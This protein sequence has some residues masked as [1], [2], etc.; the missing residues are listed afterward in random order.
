VIT[1]PESAQILVAGAGMSHYHWPDCLLAAGKPTWAVEPKD[2]APC[3]V[4]QP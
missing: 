1:R 3:K 4:C 2:L